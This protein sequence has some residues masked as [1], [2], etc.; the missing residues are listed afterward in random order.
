L[1]NLG[2]VAGLSGNRPSSL[3][4]RRA[5]HHSAMGLRR[6]M[7]LLRHFWRGRRGGA[8]K[9]FPVINSK[10]HNAMTRPVHNC[11]MKSIVLSL[12]LAVASCVT[13]SIVVAMIAAP[14]NLQSE[15][16]NMLAP[17]RATDTFRAG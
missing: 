8:T 17:P 2:R 5:L 3:Q 9:D 10:R 6:I 14:S 12:L 4:E 15:D 7:A 1:F 11:P 16:F 13:L